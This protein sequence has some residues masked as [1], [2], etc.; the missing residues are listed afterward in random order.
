MKTKAKYLAIARH[1]DKKCEAQS[2]LLLTSHMSCGQSPG[3]SHSSLPLK[4][5][6]VRVWELANPDTT[7]LQRFQDELWACLAVPAEVLFLQVSPRQASF[8]IPQHH[9]RSL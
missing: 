9:M 2:I 4:H 1:V 5:Q 8:G 6:A 3:D 7:L